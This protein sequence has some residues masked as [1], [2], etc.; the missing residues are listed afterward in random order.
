MDRFKG[1]PGP[2]HYQE[3]A[4]A[5]THIVRPDQ[6]PG[7]ILFHGPQCSGLEYE[8]NLRLASS[9]PDLLE[10]LKEAKKM[11]CSLKLSM[12]VHPDCESGSEFDDFTLRAQEVED[13]IQSVINKALANQ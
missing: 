7:R 10:A 8:S 11:I 4:D 9:A 3:G 2:W 5:Y 13:K 12:N 6:H 1:T